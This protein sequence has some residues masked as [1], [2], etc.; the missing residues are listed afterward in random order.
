MDFRFAFSFVLIAGCGPSGSPTNNSDA[1]T[2]TDVVLSDNRTSSDTS[3]NEDS[4][5][6]Q[7]ANGQSDVTSVDSG[8][9]VCTSS[10]ECMPLGSSRNQD[11][12]DFEETEDRI[13]TRGQV[14]NEECKWE[15]TGSQ[16][17]VECLPEDYCDDSDPDNVECLEDL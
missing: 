10:D 3:T 13:V 12:C 15:N 9:V 11:F 1:T 16:S 6:S 17:F 2:S 4:S 7:D 5:V 8:G 14:C